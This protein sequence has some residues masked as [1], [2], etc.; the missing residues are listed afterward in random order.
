[1]MPIIE[2]LYSIGLRMQ[3]FTDLEEAIAW[4]DGLP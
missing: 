1:M 2:S 4:L 3:V